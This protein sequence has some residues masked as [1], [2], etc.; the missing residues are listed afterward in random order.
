MSEASFSDVPALITLHHPCPYFT[1]GDLDWNVNYFNLF[2]FIIYNDTQF[3]IKTRTLTHTHAHIHTNTEEP[4]RTVTSQQQPTNNCYL[5]IYLF[6]YY[7]S[8]L[9][10]YTLNFSTGKRVSSLFDQSDMTLTIFPGPRPSN[11]IILYNLPTTTSFILSKGRRLYMLH[12]NDTYKRAHIY[13]YIPE[14]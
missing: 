7:F 1:G 13:M 4:P 2:R 3:G 14:T 10:Y 6:I 8:L 11:P 5:F 9:F 12:C